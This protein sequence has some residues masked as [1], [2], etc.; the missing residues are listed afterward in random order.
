[1]AT[2]PAGGGILWRVAAAAALLAFGP[3]CAAPGRAAPA[4]PPPV[5][6]DVPAAREPEAAA[7]APAWSFSAA[8]YTYLIPGEK[9]YVSVILGADRDRLHLEARYNYEELDTGS[10]FAGWNFAWG[11][12][13]TLELTPMV[14]AVFGHAVGVAPAYELTLAWRGLELYSEG[15]Y[16]F[17]ARGRADGFFYSWSELSW[18]PAE[19]IRGGLV[20]QSTKV[21]DTDVDVQR[22]VLLG[23]TVRDLTFT[24]YVFEFWDDPTVVL[25]LALDF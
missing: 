20:A 5:A 21:Y 14:G 4:E 10:L 12:K 2:L 25:A 17:D 15:E 24:A 7:T 16:V 1:M 6:A 22:G 23:F 19:W 9:D 18:A 11:E 8:A 3:G 13:L